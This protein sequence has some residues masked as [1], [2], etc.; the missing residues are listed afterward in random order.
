MVGTSLL[1]CHEVPYHI[2]DLSRVENL[3]YRL[4]RN[5][6]LLVYLVIC[7]C[8]LSLL[9]IYPRIF[10]IPYLLHPP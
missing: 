10:E 4:L 7:F 2:H 3:V 1:Q 8:Y 9:L 6:L 5:H